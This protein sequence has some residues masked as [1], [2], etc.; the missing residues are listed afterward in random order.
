M[1]VGTIQ[2]DRLVPK[3]C[4]IRSPYGLANGCELRDRES[5]RDGQ[6]TQEDHAQ[7]GECLAIA[8]MVRHA[9]GKHPIRAEDR[10][11]SHTSSRSGSPHGPA[12]R[13]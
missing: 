1:S 11:E 3:L 12:F 8:V 6:N 4:S 7:R 5:C 13:N 9:G 2:D 10:Q